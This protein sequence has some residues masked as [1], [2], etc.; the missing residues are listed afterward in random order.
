[1]PPTVPQPEIIGVVGAGAMGRGIAQVAAQAGFTVKLFD[2]LPGAAQKARQSIAEQLHRLQQKGK[3]TTEAAEQILLRLQP[4]EHLEQL[5]DSRIV[6]EAI[7][8][9]LEAKQTLFQTLDSVVSRDCILATNTSSLSVSVI[10]SV[11]SLPER[12]AGLHFF[13]PVPLMKVVEIISTNVTT[14]AVS[15]FLFDFVRRLGHTPVRTKDTP[16]FIVNHAS[17]GYGLEALR[18][19]QED[20]ADFSTIDFILREAAG[21]RMGPFELMDLTGLDVSLAVAQSI[22]QQYSRE[23]RYEPAAILG[24]RVAAGLLGRKVG[25]GFYSYDEQGSVIHEA[26]KEITTAPWNKSVW[27][28]KADATACDSVT[29]LLKKADAVIDTGQRPSA[30]SA[31]IVTPLGETVT[32][33]IAAENLDASRTLGIDTLLQCSQH[34]TLMHSAATD[35]T[36]VQ[37]VAALLESTGT[38]LSIIRDSPGFVVQRVLAMIVNVGCYIVEQGICTPE[39]LDRAVEL[40]LG[41]PHGPLT[42]GDAVGSRRVLEILHN[43]YRLTG[44]LRYRPSSWLER[45]AELGI[46]LRQV[47]C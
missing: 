15:D 10:A 27:V 28:S 26:A 14:P 33:C 12:L 24:N 30:D 35:R 46:S 36:F 45:R 37:Q 4:I 2:A 21:F 13:N 1:M 25:R 44:E 34:I 38:P 5:S 41:Y 9:N 16:G 43:L 7:V 47:R 42:W 32:S 6:M 23:P 20:V 29:A 3:L 18:I 22:Y 19:A 17:R 8:E 39:D 11:T 31:C 40:G